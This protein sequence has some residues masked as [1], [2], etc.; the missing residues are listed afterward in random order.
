MKPQ[1]Q[2][3]TQM[4]YEAS[5]RIADTNHLFMMMVNDGLTKKEL[6]TNID[7]RPEVWKRFESW[8]DK[9]PAGHYE[10]QP[11]DRSNG[12]TTSQEH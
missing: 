12:T 7:R 8:L 4:F 5:R 9:L 6:H 10:S 2:T 1:R 3:Q 11:L